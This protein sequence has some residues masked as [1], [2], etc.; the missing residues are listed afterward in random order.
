M[1]SM[2]LSGRETG[3]DALSCGL[4][5]VDATIHLLDKLYADIPSVVGKSD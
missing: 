5:D 3:A 4:D 2:A 1:N